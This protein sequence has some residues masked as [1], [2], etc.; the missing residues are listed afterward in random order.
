MSDALMYQNE[1]YVVL[2]P[3]APERFC[4]AAELRQELEQLLTQAKDLGPEL[5]ALATTAERVQHLL[6]TGCRWEWGEDEF[7][8]WYA[9]RLE[10]PFTPPRP[11][12]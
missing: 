3:G 4:T 7:I 6:D 11:W 1:H 2:S 5:A 8:E 12:S 9:V 10:K